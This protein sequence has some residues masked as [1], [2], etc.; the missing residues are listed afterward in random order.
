MSCILT[1]RCSIVPEEAP[2]EYVFKNKKEA[3]E[4]FKALLRERVRQHTCGIFICPS[5]QL[6]NNN[7]ENFNAEI[8]RNPKFS[9]TSKQYNLAK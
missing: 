4:A 7:T 3:S 1:W 9:G 8:L 2:K 6:D 5:S